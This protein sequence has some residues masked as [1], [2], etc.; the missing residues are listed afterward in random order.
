MCSHSLEVVEV[1]CARIGIIHHGKLIAEGT[2][3]DVKAQAKASS[4]AL[5]SAFLTLTQETTD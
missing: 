1:L 4:T 5:E 3:A 2:V